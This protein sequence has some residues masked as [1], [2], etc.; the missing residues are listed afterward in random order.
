M[1]RINLLPWRQEERQRKNNDFNVLNAGRLL[2]AGLCV[3]LCHYILY[4]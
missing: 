4:E 2:G 1:A 3:F